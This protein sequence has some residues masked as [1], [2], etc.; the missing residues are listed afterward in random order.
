M[1]RFADPVEIAG[2]VAFLAS[3][4]GDYVTGHVLTVDGG[5]AMD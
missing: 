3:S 5:V 4:D 2:A 1:G